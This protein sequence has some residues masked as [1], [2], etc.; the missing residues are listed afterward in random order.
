MAPE[1][2]QQG[3]KLFSA[4]VWS[5]AFRRWVMGGETCFP[6]AG[7]PS[8]ER[9]WGKVDRWSVAKATCAASTA[10]RA[11]RGH[12]QDTD[13]AQS[14]PHQRVEE[15][16]KKPGCQASLLSLDACSVNAKTELQR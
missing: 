11:G 14:P 2:C 6:C 5:W 12:S 7:T 10:T 8:P 4:L 3:M 1:Q 15:E 13:V 16:G 9:I